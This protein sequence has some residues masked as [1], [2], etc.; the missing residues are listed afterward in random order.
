M[1]MIKGVRG[2]GG[3]ALLLDSC[4]LLFRH[5]FKLTTL[6]TASEDGTYAFPK[7]MPPCAVRP[8]GGVVV[9]SMLIPY[10]S[11]KRLD[12]KRVSLRLAGNAVIEFPDHWDSV[13]FMALVQWRHVSPLLRLPVHLVRL[14]A[15]QLGNQDWCALQK[16]C[17]QMWEAVAL[18]QQTRRPD[19]VV[20]Y[21]VDRETL[22]IYLKLHSR[23]GAAALESPLRGF[24]VGPG[25][26]YP[27]FIADAATGEAKVTPLQYAGWSAGGKKLRFDALDHKGKRCASMAHDIQ[28][29][30]LLPLVQDL[31]VEFPEEVDFHAGINIPVVFHRGA[32]TPSWPRE[33]WLLVGR[34]SQTRVVVPYNLKQDSFSYNLVFGSQQPRATAEVRIAP[35]QEYIPRAYEA[36][37]VVATTVVT[38]KMAFDDAWFRFASSRLVCGQSMRLDYRVPSSYDWAADSIVLSMGSVTIHSIYLPKRQGKLS[39]DG[40]WLEGSLVVAM[41]GQGECDKLNVAWVNRHHGSMIPLKS[42]RGGYVLVDEWESRTAS[43]SSSSSSSSSWW[44]WKK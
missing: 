3:G 9:D 18:Q 2:G 6:P 43:S 5:Q 15:G 31:R 16:S 17:R 41:P 8:D 38:D 29:P 4:L 23:P 21:R 36:G 1:C 20:S 26:T 12:E 14:I 33:F 37:P 19:V 27:S 11:A 40:K 22:D 28:L 35:T 13:T 25:Q 30:D 34:K 24:S 10:V 32:K 7:A 44:P 42:D 39:S